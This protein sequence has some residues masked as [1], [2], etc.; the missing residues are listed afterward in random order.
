[1]TLG[2]DVKGK[3]TKESTVR[4]KLFRATAGLSLYEQSH[5]A[6]S[7]ATTGNNVLETIQNMKSRSQKQKQASK[8]STA[9]FQWLHDH[10]H[11]KKIEQTATKDVDA[12]VLRLVNSE[13]P[14]N[15]HHDHSYEAVIAAAVTE[16]QTQRL[17]QLNV[18]QNDRDNRNTMRRLLASIQAEAPS[19]GPTWY[20]QVKIQLQ[21]LMLDSIVG[22]HMLTEQLSAEA[23]ACEKE[24]QV[25]CQALCRQHRTAGVT[26][27]GASTEDV[28]TQLMAATQ[29]QR[30]EDE[31]L[32]DGVDPILKYNLLL[33]FETLQTQLEADLAG[34]EEGYRAS[35]AAYGCAVEQVT[36]TPP[37]HPGWTDEDHERYLK[38]FKDCEPKGIRNEAFLKRLEPLLPQRSRKDLAAH[39]QW[40]RTHRRHLQQTQERQADYTRQHSHIFEKAKTQLADAIETHRARQSSQAELARRAAAQAVLH[41]KVA[42]FQ[43]KRNVKA[44]MAAHQSEIARLEAQA[45][46][47][48]ME[49][50]RK[51][52][53]EL[54]KKLVQ[55]H[56]GWQ[57]LGAIAD[58]EAAAVARAREDEA[59]AA[60]AVINAER[61]QHRM[62]EWEHKT[63]LQ[64]QQLQRQ[65]DEEAARRQALEALK[66]ET[67]YAAKLAEIQID[68]ERT[69]QP[70]VAFQANVDAA[71]EPLGVHVFLR[72]D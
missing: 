72:V 35:M 37:K 1:M 65:Q 3:K 17:G 58:E 13:L 32:S 14:V 19:K 69:R 28:W 54:K 50:K 26:T 24:L 29:P 67:P 53:H 11:L 49:A 41:E 6:H 2:G 46:Q 52:E 38:V 30:D 48:A 8:E 12:T 36:A 16:M 5:L 55:E 34:L 70:T 9:K 56:K 61:V 25:A 42:R 66:L 68:P 27:P 39:D 57:E 63:E 23:E 59:K 62:D 21:N 33:E 7:V 18:H 60:Q 51:K 43:L 20:S 22:H 15:D 45:L 71:Q 44:E 64:K 10:M 47:E 31:A 4:S 40:H